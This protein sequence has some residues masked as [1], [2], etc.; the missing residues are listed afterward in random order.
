MLHC[1]IEKNTIQEK[2]NCE[3]LEQLCCRNTQRSYFQ[4]PSR[5]KC[6]LVFEK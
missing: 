5:N 6:F 1:T 2:R 3:F 4:N